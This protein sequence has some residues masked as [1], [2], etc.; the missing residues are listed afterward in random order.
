MLHKT[1]KS[2]QDEK[3]KSQ[4]SE[5]SV[6]FLLHFKYHPKHALPAQERGRARTACMPG[7]AGG[8]HVLP[9]KQGW[10]LE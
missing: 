7:K 1:L 5:G 10:S 8:L 2:A 3:C 9:S 4:N 6:G